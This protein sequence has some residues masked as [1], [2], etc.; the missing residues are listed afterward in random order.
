MNKT[1]KIKKPFVIIS[2]EKNDN[3]HVANEER[4]LNLRQD[5]EKLGYCFKN[6]T[7]FYK[8]AK[9]QSIYTELPSDDIGELFR[10][11]EKLEQESILFVDCFRNAKLIYTDGTTKD[12]GTFKQVSR[13]EAQQHDSFTFDHLCNGYYICE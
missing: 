12:I 10:L 11:A 7:G 3:S 4:T 9:E 2:A 6:V 5:I 13:D 8:G 1:D